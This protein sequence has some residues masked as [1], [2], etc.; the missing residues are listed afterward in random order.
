MAEI[1]ADVEGGADIPEGEPTDDD[2][3]QVRFCFRLSRIV[4]NL[5]YLC[6]CF[7]HVFILCF[8]SACRATL[9]KEI[10]MGN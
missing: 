4:Q 3:N 2:N 7:Q 1:E 6:V 10:V 8:F 9:R 5:L